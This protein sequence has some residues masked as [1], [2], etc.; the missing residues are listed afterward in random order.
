MFKIERITNRFV[1]IKLEKEEIRLAIP[2]DLFQKVRNRRL[3]DIKR[4]RKILY[5]DNI[6]YIF[7]KKEWKLVKRLNEYQIIRNPFE[8]I[9]DRYLSR[10][11]IIGSEKDFV[12]IPLKDFEEARDLNFKETQLDRQIQ[13]AL[14]RD[15]YKFTKEQWKSAENLAESQQ[16]SYGEIM[17]IYKEAIRDRKKIM[18][19]QAKQ[20][21]HVRNR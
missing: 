3:R 8:F 1:F 13:L 18:R 16:N 6:R 15:L 4:D 20:K 14:G 19:R 17:K 21:L 9:K 7:K 5:I 10:G 2:F 11:V 12:I